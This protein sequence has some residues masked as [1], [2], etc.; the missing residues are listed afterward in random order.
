MA[1]NK[2]GVMN[3]SSVVVTAKCSFLCETAVSSPCISTSP[4]CH[5]VHFFAFSNGIPVISEK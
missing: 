3:V 5:C 1:L 4:D 2:C